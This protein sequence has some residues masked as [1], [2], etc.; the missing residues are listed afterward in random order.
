MDKAP[1][2]SLR[3]TFERRWLQS[4]FSTLHCRL[5]FAINGFLSF[6]FTRRVNSA[7]LLFPDDLAEIVFFK[8]RDLHGMQ[9]LERARRSEAAA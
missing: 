6:S 4:S 8:M 2:W 1:R 5:P 3:A 7:P 9:I